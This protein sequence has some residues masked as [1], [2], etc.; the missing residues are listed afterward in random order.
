MHVSELKGWRW[1]KS[2]GPVWQVG[3]AVNLELTRVE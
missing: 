2:L 1:A 3:G